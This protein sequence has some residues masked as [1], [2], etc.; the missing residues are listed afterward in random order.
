MKTTTISYL[1]RSGRPT[2]VTVPNTGLRAKLARLRDSGAYLI[3]TT[4]T[5][6]KLQELL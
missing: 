2:R 1:T 4:P 3:R 6:A 5:G